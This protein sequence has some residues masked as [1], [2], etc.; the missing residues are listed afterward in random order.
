MFGIG[1]DVRPGPGGANE[2]LYKLSP[3]RGVELAGFVQAGRHQFVSV[4]ESL[5]HVCILQM[6]V[7]PDWRHGR[8]RTMPDDAGDTVGVFFGRVLK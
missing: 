1:R 3:T 2:E 6:S 4:G 8:R 5:A 7:A